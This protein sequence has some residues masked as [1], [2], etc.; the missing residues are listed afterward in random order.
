MMGDVLRFR[1]VGPLLIKNNYDMAKTRNILPFSRRRH[2]LFVCWLAEKFV[3]CTKF[4]DDILYCAKRPND[5][6]HWTIDI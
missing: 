4:K 6:V 5:F 1:T 3:Q 2:S